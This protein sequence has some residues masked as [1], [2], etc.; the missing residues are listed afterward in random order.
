MSVT[1]GECPTHLRQ[2]GRLA[3]GKTHCAGGHPAQHEGTCVCHLPPPLCSDPSPIV[4]DSLEQ[5]SDEAKRCSSQVSQ[6]TERLTG[7]RPASADTLNDLLALRHK[8]A[9]PSFLV[10]KRL[11][12]FLCVLLSPTMRDVETFQVIMC[13]FPI[14]SVGRHYLLIVC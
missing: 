12:T 2:L 11:S 5:D 3:K 4:L 1:T 6:T 7:R 14:R 13:M 9:C 8:E 10:H